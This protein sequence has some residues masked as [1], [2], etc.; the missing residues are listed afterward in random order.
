MSD[1]ASPRDERREDRG[2]QARTPAWLRENWYRDVWLF[3]ISLFCAVSIPV[4]YSANKD[5]I[6]DVQT[7]RLENVRR[8]CEDSN[9]KNEHAKAKVNALRSQG[10]MSPEG[11]AVT[12]TLIDSLSEVHEDCEA[13]ARQVVVPPEVPAGD[14]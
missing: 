11:A 7:S 6:A 10:K 2:P 4:F 12:K 8:G 13:Y 14:G 1:D 5:R 3:L 9:A